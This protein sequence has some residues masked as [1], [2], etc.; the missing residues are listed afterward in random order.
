M[1]LDALGVS[2]R[3][4]FQAICIYISRV[5]VTVTLDEDYSLFAVLV[6]HFKAASHQSLDVG[7]ER[8]LLSIL[9]STIDLGKGYFE[10]ILII[11]QSIEYLSS[12]PCF[13]K[14]GHG[15][16]KEVLDEFEVG[17]TLIGGISAEVA[18]IVHEA[19][20]GN[21]IEDATDVA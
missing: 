20:D 12:R 21:G 7:T 8:S 15:I 16:V 17:V 3:L 1:P 14:G 2:V 18:S 13:P 4:L 9:G 11:P 10:P 5:I 6:K 19:I